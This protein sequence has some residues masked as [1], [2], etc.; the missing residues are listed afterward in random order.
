MNCKRYE[1]LLIAYMDGRATE[2]ESIEVDRHLLACGECRVRVAEYGRL[3]NVLEEAP[4]LRISPAFD[5]RLRARIAT[6]PQRTWLSWLPAP[7][8]AFAAAML[9]ML[10]A[11]V[12]T[13]PPAPVD[14]AAPLNA[15]RGEEEARAVKDLQSL[16]DLDVLVNF[17]ALSELPKAKM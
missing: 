4:T 15:A 7:R 9:L 8:V 3:W 1:S 14:T 16:E 12:G 11:W 2:A 13:G 5:A 10:S 17:E 6:E